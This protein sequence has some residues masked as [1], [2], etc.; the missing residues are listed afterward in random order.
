MIFLG[1]IIQKLYMIVA[2]MMLFHITPMGQLSQNHNNHN[3]K[4]EFQ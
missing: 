3:N 1:K 2:I 4:E